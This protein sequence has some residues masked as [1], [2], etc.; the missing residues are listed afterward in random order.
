MYLNDM[1]K[2][3]YDND[4][5]KELESYLNELKK[6]M[7]EEINKTRQTRKGA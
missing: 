7:I 2:N 4:E 5:R 1:I 3:T 6:E